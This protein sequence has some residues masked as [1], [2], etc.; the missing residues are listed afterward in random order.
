MEW[1]LHS[2]YFTLFNCF[3]RVGRVLWA[4]SF[5]ISGDSTRHAE[6][7]FI[8]QYIFTQLMSS[9]SV[10]WDRGLGYFDVDIHPHPAWI[11]IIIFISSDIVLLYALLSFLVF[12]YLTFWFWY[13][14]LP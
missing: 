11:W 5:Q 4:K 12:E 3:V 9:A 13:T 14:Y 2:V 7:D 8:V 6:L 10:D 1:K